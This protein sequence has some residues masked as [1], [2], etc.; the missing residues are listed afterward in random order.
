MVLTQEWLDQA[1]D[2][3]KKNLSLSDWDIKIK[4]IDPGDLDDCSGD[5]RFFLIHRIGEI[6]V[7]NGPKELRDLSHWDPE[8]VIIHEL[9]HLPVS[10]MCE[11]SRIEL[12]DVLEERFIN[13]IT[14]SLLKLRKAAAEAYNLGKENNNDDSKR[15]KRSPSAR[16]KKTRKSSW[17]GRKG[18]CSE[19]SKG[20]G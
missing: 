16:G 6:R 10:F 18:P 19:G 9:L 20:G 12:N 7:A 15:R 11:V 1:L 5:H 2:F 17:W 4:W 3:W 8:F 13:D 14:R